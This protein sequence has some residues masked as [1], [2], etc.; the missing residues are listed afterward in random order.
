LQVALDYWLEYA[1]DAGAVTESE[2]NGLWDR[3]LTTLNEVAKAQEEHQEGSDPTRRFLELISAALASGRAHVASIAGNPPDTAEAWGWRWGIGE[4][5]DEGR[6]CGERIGWIAGDDLFLEPEASYA[7]A[8]R[9]ARDSGDSITVASKTLHKRL[10]ERGLL[11]STDD[12]RRK[13]TVRR[14]LE[15]RRRAVLHL[16]AD[17]ISAPERT[18]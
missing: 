4:G 7:V 6:P 5:P 8:Q 15:G 18:P 14:V 12:R 11:A 10:H 1:E 16:K 13:L 9:L 2:A 3:A 17:L